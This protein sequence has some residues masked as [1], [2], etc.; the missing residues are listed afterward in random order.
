[1][2]LY[3]KRNLL[4]VIFAVVISILSQIVMPVSAVLEQKLMILL[5]NVM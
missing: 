2:R 5:Y 1:M 4:L 3:Y